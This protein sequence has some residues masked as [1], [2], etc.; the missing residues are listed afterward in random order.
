MPKRGR[1]CKT[2][3]RGNRAHRGGPT[4]AR[5]PGHEGTV[6]A[7]PAVRP[8]PGYPRIRLI[9]GRQLVDLL[10][11]HWYDIPAEFHDRLGLKPG[12]VRR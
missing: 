11:E 5:G 3:N 7:Q 9:N 6:R 12:L 10:V 4:S 1:P 8:A 2:S